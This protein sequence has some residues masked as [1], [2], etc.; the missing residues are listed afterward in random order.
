M[1]LDYQEEFDGMRLNDGS[2]TDAFL[3][4]SDIVIYVGNR[5]VGK[6]HLI[7]SKSLPHIGK[8]YYRAVYFRKMIKDSQTSGGISDKSKSIFG[9]FGRYNESLQLMTWKFDSG[10]RI[11]FGN[12]SASESDFSENVQGIEYY[13]AYIDEVTQISEDRFN[14]I[15]SNLRNTKGERTQIFGTC[16]A[17]PNSW[18]KHLISWY[19][20]P[21]T[22]FHIPERSGVERY[23][24]QWGDN[25]LESYWGDTREEVLEQ[26]ESHINQMWDSK[27]EEYGSKLDLIQSITVFEG[28][29]SENK[30][31][32]RSSGVKYYGKLLKGSNE[33]KGRYAR[34]CWKSPDLGDSA[35]SDEDMER[36]FS[37]SEQR[38]GTKYA[39]LDVA[40]SGQN[41]DKVVLWIWDGYHV[42]DVHATQGLKPN[43][44]LDWTKRHLSRHGVRNENFI[45]DGVGVGWIFD[46]FFEESVKFMS[47][48][49][50]SEDSKV[51]FDK[52][53]LN[54]YRNAKAEVV[55]N[56]LDALKNSEGTGECGLSISG[57]VLSKELFGKT[58]REHLMEEKRVIMWREDREGV[59]QLIDRK[60]TKRILGHSPD[61]ILSLIYRM[62]LNRKF[63]QM[64][65]EQ[66]MELINFLTF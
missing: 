50:A 31:L 62:A 63:V 64:S 35:I 1:I 25:I 3:C 5:G 4:E 19:L 47:Q 45:Y 28:K 30:H 60:E 10:A 16:N 6:T 57:M 17:D 11:V 66:A 43:E 55:G 39:S 44:L 53:K 29:M 12:Y 22:G 61:F 20:D 37:N 54:V 59:K 48:S 18:I 32:M 26:A 46:G 33:M 65:D 7:L 15:Y 52:R 23:F 9:Q 51:E 41:A 36:F 24:Y 56:F 58:V 2:Q 38:D 27:M 49:A 42:V 40:G 34:A 21:E 8:P 13:H 14:A